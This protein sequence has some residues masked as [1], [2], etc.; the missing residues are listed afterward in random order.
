[1]FPFSNVCGG[2]F[3]CSVTICLAYLFFQLFLLFIQSNKVEQ[4]Y[5]LCEMKTTYFRIAWNV[6][7]IFTNNME[8]QYE[9][10]IC[11]CL[12][13]NEI[14][15]TIIWSWKNLSFFSTKTWFHK[16]WKK[17]QLYIE[18]NTRSRLILSVAKNHRK[19]ICKTVHISHLVA[20]SALV[21]DMRLKSRYY[22][23]YYKNNQ[24]FYRRCET[25]RQEHF[26]SLFFSGMSIWLTAKLNS[27]NRII[28]CTA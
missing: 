24:L 21:T 27:W 19:R 4:I 28:Y 15:G 9:Y 7:V 6:I 26:N 2:Q 10:N 16:L 12:N 3:A 11:I 20:S 5:R 1:M 22:H 25:V 17:N 23:Y 13:K 18:Y 14:D 8:Y